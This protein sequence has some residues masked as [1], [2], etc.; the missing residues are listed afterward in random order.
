VTSA[1]ETL[2]KRV[3]SVIDMALT[4]VSSLSEMY[5]GGAPSITNDAVIRPAEKAPNKDAPDANMAMEGEDTGEM[6]EG[7]EA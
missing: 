2:R 4:T 5:S 3:E 7:E 1:N 6:S